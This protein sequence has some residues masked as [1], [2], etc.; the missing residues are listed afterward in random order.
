[1]NHALEQKYGLVT[2]VC[3]VVGA[4]IGSGIFFLNETVFNATGGRLYLAVAAWLIGGLIMFAMM[5]VWGQLAKSMQGMNGLMDYSDALVSKKFSYFLSWFLGTI[6]Y[7]SFVAVLAW[8]SAR[9]TAT[10]LGW[11][12][13]NT[14]GAVWMLAGVYLIAIYV[15]NVISPKLAG[16]FQ[17]S[18]T[19]IKV[20]PLILM[21]FAGIIFGLANGTMTENL[22]YVRAAE[23][24]AGNPL[25]LAIL[26][27]VF[28]YAGAE[29]VLMMNSEIANPKRNLPRAII[30]GS[31]LIIGIYV[32]YTIGVFGSTYADTLRTPG[33]IRLGFENMF[34]HAFGSV[35]IVFIIISC[36]GAMN[37]AMMAASRAFY[38]IA[39]RGTGPAPEHVRSVDA[40]TNMPATSAAISLIFCGL[41]MVLIFANAQDYPYHIR[42]FGD[43]SI[44]ITSLTPIT[45]MSFYVPIFIAVMRKQKAWTVFNRFVMPGLAIGGALLLIYM[46]FDTNP[47]GALIYL[48]GFT[49]MMGIGALLRLPGRRSRA[50][51]ASEADGLI[52]A[53]VVE[54]EAVELAA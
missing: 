38:S 28:A 15:M 20:I 16:K 35:L 37:S 6:L 21:G 33:G 53:S 34:G 31:I 30:I 51:A 14:S 24:V 17:V 48:A 49:A 3:L 2:A 22:N 1:M 52:T 43:I 11:S 54:E 23:E 12:Q 44:P 26:A 50:L 32:F 4:V 27:T 18:T 5:Y 29:E 13:P 39:L 9:F 41:M 25:Y 47:I 10:L 7:P 36:L 8:V 42:W 40:K 46:S 45:L 19:A